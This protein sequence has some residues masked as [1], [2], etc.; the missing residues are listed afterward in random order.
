MKLLQ[1]PKCAIIQDSEKNKYTFFNIGYKFFSLD[2]MKILSAT[3]PFY[4]IGRRVDAV[5]HRQFY[6][7][8]THT[9]LHQPPKFLCNWA[10]DDRYLAIPFVSLGLIGWLHHDPYERRRGQIFATGLMW[11]FAVKISLKEIKTDA[12]LRP[13]NE[14][15]DRHER[16]HGGNPSG[17]MTI[18]AYMA[19]F[20][21]LE[22]GWRAAIPL[23][24]FTAFAFSMNVACNH[25]YFSQAVAG[26]GLGV[27]M[28]YATHAAFRDLKMPEDVKVALGSDHKGNLALKFAYEF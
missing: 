12:N 17:H 3:M 11:S 20:W 25:H 27:M 26:T 1:K 22:K 4:L 15:F 10:L 23:S 14:N 6:D 2:T 21:A 7:I 5:V 13:W 19:T 28:G 16:A 9:N 18:T 8:E 24:M